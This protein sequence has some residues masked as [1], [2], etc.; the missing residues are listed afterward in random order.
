MPAWSAAKKPGRT[1]PKHLC[2]VHGLTGQGQLA[3]LEA[4]QIKQFVYQMPHP[5]CLFV[6]DRCCPSPGLI[7]V[8]CAIEQGL[9]K[10]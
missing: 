9:E 10:P 6:D 8:R 7:I 4:G 1:D 5:P 2:D 3:R